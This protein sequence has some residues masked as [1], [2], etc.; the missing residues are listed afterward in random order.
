MLGGERVC[1]YLSIVQPD[2]EV[3]QCVCVCVF[4]SIACWVERKSLYLREYHTA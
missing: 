3:A 2:M 4:G 1:I